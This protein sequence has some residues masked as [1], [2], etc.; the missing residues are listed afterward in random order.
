[1]SEGSDGTDQ[2]RA[3]RV[4]E[5]GGTHGL[6]EPFGGSG[7]DRAAKPSGMIRSVPLQQGGLV[8][9]QFTEHSFISAS[10]SR[11]SPW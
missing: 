11:A 6:V 7:G 2:Q 10:T 1:M 9:M 8:T 5:F 4:T 3:A